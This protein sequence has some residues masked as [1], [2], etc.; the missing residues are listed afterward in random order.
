MFGR[1]ISPASSEQAAA[2]PRTTVSYAFGLVRGEREILARGTSSL[3]RATATPSLSRGARERS[4][5]AARAVAGRDTC[6]RRT[7]ARTSLTSSSAAPV[8][9]TMKKRVFSSVGLNSSETLMSGNAS[10]T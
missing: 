6:R 10:Q 9:G 5:R 4:S 3:A 8:D 1:S 2:P 7:H